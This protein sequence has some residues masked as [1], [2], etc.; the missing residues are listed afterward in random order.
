MKRIL[1]ALPLYLV[2][3]CG[4]PIPQVTVEGGNP[5]NFVIS[6]RTNLL[7]FEICCVEGSDQIVHINDLWEIR[8]TQSKMPFTI[9]YGTLPEGFWQ[10]TP[11]DKQLPHS[12]I[13]GKKYI[14]AAQGLYGAKIGC[15]IIE[16]GKAKAIEC[17]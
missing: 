13:E 2:I 8:S 14:Y 11:K 5:P 4:E 10:I 7:G 12:L 9:T 16:D 3:S 6:G 1:L 17:K 15:F